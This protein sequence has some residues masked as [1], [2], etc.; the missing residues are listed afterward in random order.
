L[1]QGSPSR[2]SRQL[3]DLANILAVLVFPVPLGPQNKYACA[4]LFDITEYFRV[5]T[6]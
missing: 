2:G 6:I 5:L 1:L 4:I 3:T